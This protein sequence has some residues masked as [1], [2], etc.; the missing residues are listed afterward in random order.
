MVTVFPI[1]SWVHPAAVPMQPSSEE[2]TKLRMAEDRSFAADAGL[3]PHFMD[4]PGASNIG[5][6]SFNLSRLT[7]NFARVE[8]PL[9][10]ELNS[11]AGSKQA[12]DRPWLFCPAGI[13]GHVDHVAVRNIVMAHAEDLS[14]HFRIAYYEDLHYASRFRARILGL[15]RLFNSAGCRSLKRS[16]FKLD[17]AS[18]ARK[19]GLIAHYASQ[20]RVRPTDL[21]EYSPATL[22]TLGSHEAIWSAEKPPKDFQMATTHFELGI[23]LS[24]LIARLS[25]LVD[26]KSA[27]DL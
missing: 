23:Y 12:G 14:R 18:I 27:G 24:K 10:E 7:E 17:A 9:I 13:G 3:S 6:G 16:V 20:I 4:L 19:C 15:A 26:H 25:R 8:A 1:A 21:G 11:I 5:W 22:P 2:V